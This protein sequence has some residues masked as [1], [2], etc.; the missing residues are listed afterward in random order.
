VAPG[1]YRVEPN[2]V[3]ALSNAPGVSTLAR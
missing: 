3:P 2:G 1:A